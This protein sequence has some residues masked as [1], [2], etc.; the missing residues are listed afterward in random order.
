MTPLPDPVWPIVVLALIQLVDAVM[1]IKPV[2]FIADCL[3]GVR[4]PRRLWQLLPPIKIAAALGLVIGI[5][6]PYLG[7]AASIGLVAYFLVAIAMH[8]RARDFRRYLFVNATGM[9]LV[10]VA[11]LIFSFLI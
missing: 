5:W 10:C 6:V 3:E 11:V 4:L 9:L 7:L 1:S 2:P 8:L